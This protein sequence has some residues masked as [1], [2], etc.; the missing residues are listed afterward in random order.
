MR[1]KREAIAR[2]RH[3]LGE[4][5]ADSQLTNRYLWSALWDAA[6]LLMQR[7]YDD[8][9]LRD[10]AVFETYNLDTEE[11]NPFD[12]TCVPLD[13]IACRVKVPEPAMSKNGP[14][15]SFLGSPDMTTQYAIVNAQEFAVKA[16]VKGIRQRFAFYENG[17]LML[18]KCIPCVKFTVLPSSGMTSSK[19]GVMD[20][21]C[22]VPD[23][24]F[25]ASVAIARENIA[26]AVAKPYDHVAN[27]NETA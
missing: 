26:R 20:T 5:S 19:C 8:G 17:Y 4:H 7:S 22:Q 6:K 21:E 25:D 3:D 15:Y 13:C 24:L 23:H 9:S 27:K 16:K 1:T 2:L 10:Q 14:V 18:S 11:Y 12:G